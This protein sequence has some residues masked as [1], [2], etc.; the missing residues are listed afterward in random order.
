MSHLRTLHDNWTVRPV[1]GRIPDHVS[2]AGPIAATVPGTVHT[3]LLAAGLIPDPYLDDNERLL[4]W[5]GGASWCYETVFQYPSNEGHAELV[6][7]GLD[8]V[9]RIELNGQLLGETGNMHR[10]YRF[11]AAGALREG[12]NTLTVT[13]G[14]AI[15]YANAM[16]LEQGARP[17]V[18]HHPYNAIR[19][20]ACNFGWDW[21][22]DL[23]TAGIWRPVRLHTWS[24]AR[25]VA[26][27]PVT[28][29]SGSDGGVDLHLDLTG[30]VQDTVVTA[31]I[32]GH[33]V[34]APGSASMTM[35]LEA[36]QVD[37]W[38]PRGHGEQPL[39]DLDVTLSDSSGRCLDRWSARLGF[40]TVRLDPDN[41]TFVVNDRP[42]F[43]KGANWIP[44][45]AF[46]HRV[47]S[48]APRL[49]QAQEAGVNLLRVWGGGIYEADGF[50][51]ECDARGIMTW[52]DFLF[53]C[54]CYSEEEPLRSEVIAEARDNITRLMT[55]P[56]L[57]LWNGG[58]EN[59]WGHVDWGWAPRLDGQTWGLGYYEEILPQ[60]V[61]SLDPGRPYTPGSPWSP[62]SGRHPN[63]PDHGSMHIWDVWN[64]LDYR[65]YRRYRPRFV[66][67]FGWQGPPAW[68][69]LRRAVSDEPLTPQSPGMQVHQKAGD[70][71]AKLTSGLVSHFRVPSTMDDWHWAMS[72]NQ[73]RAIG[74][75]VEYFRSLVP[76]CS[77]SVIWQL[78]DC[79]PAVS[80]A[81]IDGDGRRKPA[82]YALRRAH[83]DR[84]LTIQPHAD[85]LS[86]VL[87]NDTAAAWSGSIEVA[88]CTY[89]GKTLASASLPVD[90][91]PRA[92][93]T[94]Q[95]PAGVT[96]PARP[97]AELVVATAAEQRALWFFAE[98]RDSE[99]E[100]PVLDARVE[101]TETGVQ[102]TITAAN[103]VKDLALLADKIDPDAVVDDL[104]CTLLP[105]E[106]VTWQ[107][108]TSAPADERAWL[109]ASVLRSANELV[110]PD[111][112]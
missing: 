52:Q 30:V 58:N 20:M 66:A 21:G 104:L 7:D 103:L 77:G 42:V 12:A 48:Y 112:L 78:N 99:L 108:T 79:W 36:G 109:A 3:D 82:F 105:G 72:L 60:L 8:T 80:W 13:F 98:D 64:Q 89:D 76:E 61:A 38:W 2:A 85:G 35:R 83:A 53:A 110:H 65:E 4:A 32:N 39:Y 14:S 100:P 15:A 24:T 63:D 19:K 92:V 81:M 6:F 91:P 73:A 62:G 84:L 111:R 23:V 45:D 17:H 11:D 71:D 10:T 97:S 9:A 18:N 95:V 107:V 37:R 5:I 90:C 22:P 68:A 93:R 44:D 47:T 29:V 34:T 49:A 51:A 41:F 26:A 25:I 1:S 57:V 88:R 67:E 55:H 75:A 28:R 87:V 69:T 96:E 70:G 40:R 94:M 43:V 27:R 50:Y 102:V 101:P 86:V 46:P 106:T 16:S 31:V 54:A 74:T 33:S 56:S 59:L